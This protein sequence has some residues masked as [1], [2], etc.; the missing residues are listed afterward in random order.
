MKCERCGNEYPSSYYFATPTICKDCFS[1]LTPE[2]L[3]IYRNLLIDQ[4]KFHEFDYRIGFGRRLGAFLIDGLILIF[5]ISIIFLSTGFL[6]DTIRLFKESS[7]SMSDS[8]YIAELQVQFESEHIMTFIVTQLLILAFFSLEILVAASP[9]KLALGIQIAD[10]S[11]KKAPNSQLIERFIYKHLYTI[12][13]LA[14]M[15]IGIEV[16]DWISNILVLGF[17]IGCFFVLSERR[18]GFHDMIAHTAVFHKEDIIYDNIIN[19]NYKVI[20]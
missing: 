13:T 8:R 5:L 16:L 7:E 17:V 12:F 6:N 1:K 9:G 3:E 11:R 4:P 14:G 20:S 18:Q 19:N 15:I 2:E 10:E